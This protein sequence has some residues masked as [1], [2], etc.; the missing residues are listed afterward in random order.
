MNDVEITL[1]CQGYKL[2]VRLIKTYPFYEY[3]C[4]YVSIPKG[5]PIYGLSDDEIYEQFPDVYEMA[6]GGITYAGEID[7][8]WWIGFDTSHAFDTKNTRSL[9]YVLLTLKKLLQAVMEVT[10]EYNL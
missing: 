10:N 6:H 3:R 7:G 9:G 2:M 5:H 4:G 1:N 8:E